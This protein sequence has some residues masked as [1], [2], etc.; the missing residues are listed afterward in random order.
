MRKIW[1]LSLATIVF[2]SCEK[3]DICEGG[4]SKTPNVIINMYD[5]FEPELLKPAAKISLIA[6]GFKDTLVFKNRSKIE[7]PLQINTQETTWSIILHEYSPGAVNDTIIKKDKLRFLYNT[8]EFY[9]SK[10]CG[11]KV[12]FLDFGASLVPSQDP[13]NSWIQSISKLT[14]EITNENNAHIYLYY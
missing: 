7:I 13:T 2:S 8:E 12:N 1:F 10:A 14:N 4:E 11:Y 9:V 5:S 6:D 3:D